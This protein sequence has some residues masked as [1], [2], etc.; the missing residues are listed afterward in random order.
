MKAIILVAGEGTRLRPLTFD[1][2]KALLPIASKPLLE[3]TI[4]LLKC[5][6]IAQIAL[7]LHHKPEV[8]TK[9]FGDGRDFGVEITYSLEESIL[10]TA[11]AVKKLEGYFDDTFVVVYG[12]VLTNVNIRSLV[13]FH[14]IQRGLGTI[15]VYQVDDPSACGLV[16]LGDHWR[17]TRFAEKP[18]PDEIFT[19]LANTGI[20][21]L[22]PEVI[23]YIPSGTFYDFGHDLF[24]RLLEEGVPMY[25]YPISDTD[26]L[27]DIGTIDHYERA[28]REWPVICGSPA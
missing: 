7:N 14:D 13:S 6:G 12:D 9:H 22:E 21:V 1:C 20:F 25:G 8:I 5:H 19:D 17:I 2:P 24:P 3:H 4:D 11:G 16:E 28:Q 15:A 10:G 23:D 26:Y 18:P 27:L